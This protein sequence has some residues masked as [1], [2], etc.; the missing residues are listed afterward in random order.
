VGV[1]GL[2]VQKGRTQFVP[3]F[4]LDL[5]ELLEAEEDLLE[6]FLLGRVELVAGGSGG[7]VLHFENYIVR[8]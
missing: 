3:A 6:A 5:V 8:W 1:Q 2:L 4:V 7:K